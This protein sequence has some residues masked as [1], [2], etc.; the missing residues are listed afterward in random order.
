[1][2]VIE[3]WAGAQSAV[4]GLGWGELYYEKLVAQYFHRG[5]GEVL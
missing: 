4:L 2:N 5:L 3:A 1:M